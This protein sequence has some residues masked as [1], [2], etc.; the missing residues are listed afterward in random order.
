MSIATDVQDI[1]QEVFQD[2]LQDTSLTTDTRDI[3]QEIFNDTLVGEGIAQVMTYHSVDVGQTYDPES[4]DYTADTGSAAT[5]TAPGLNGITQVMTYHSAYIWANETYDPKTGQYT[6][7][8]GDG[9]LWF[10]DEDNSHWV[11]WG[12]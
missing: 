6:S 8:P 5:Y 7:S 4:G 12:L 3:L 2:T 10:N 9:A 1:L 11:G